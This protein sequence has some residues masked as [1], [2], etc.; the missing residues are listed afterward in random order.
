M[1]GF[2]T[3]TVVNQPNNMMSDNPLFPP[4][5]SLQCG[6]VFIF[7]SPNRTGALLMIKNKRLDCQAE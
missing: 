7:N 1:F 3:D 5:P 4:G 6:I 2:V